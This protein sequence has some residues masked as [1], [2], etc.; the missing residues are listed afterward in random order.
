MRFTEMKV[1]FTHTLFCKNNF[2]RTTNLKKYEQQELKK[3]MS[4]SIFERELS[5]FLNNS[6]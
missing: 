1:A 2:I 6:F 4:K 5:E 3:P